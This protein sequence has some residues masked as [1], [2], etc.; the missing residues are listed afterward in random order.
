MTVT[1][2]HHRTE[3]P[4]PDADTVV[5]IGSLGSDRSMWD[6]QVGALSASVHVLTVDLRGHGRSPVPPAPI[7]WPISPVTFLHCWIHS[8]WNAS[9][10]S[11]SPSAVPSLNGLRFIAPSG[12]AL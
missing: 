2:A 12:C 4:H 10:W 8:L 3:G 1:L 11:D 6:P 7:P 9:T 5:L